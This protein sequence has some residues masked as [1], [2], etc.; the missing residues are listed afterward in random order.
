MS[1]IA[2]KA[3]RGSE[4]ETLSTH[5]ENWR[6]LGSHEW[7]R[8][9]ATPHLYVASMVYSQSVPLRVLAA[10]RSKRVEKPSAS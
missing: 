1:R 5:T 2:K 7:L 3:M 9:R 6:K 4:R 8:K 10:S